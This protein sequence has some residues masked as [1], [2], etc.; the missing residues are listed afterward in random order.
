MQLLQ[1]FH[2]SKG[3]LTHS[4]LEVC[5]WLSSPTQSLAFLK[6]SSLFFLY[7][8]FT[9]SP[10]LRVKMDTY[11]VRQMTAEQLCNPGDLNVKCGHHKRAAAEHV[12]KRSPLSSE[13]TCLS[14]ENIMFRLPGLYDKNNPMSKKTNKNK[15][16]TQNSI[17]DHI[18]SHILF[19]MSTF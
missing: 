8:A 5:D 9:E 3:F 13:L 4:K 7:H 6:Q 15:K 2:H 17:T 19:K 10:V 11:C 1:V 16:P 14:Q 18:K 12:H